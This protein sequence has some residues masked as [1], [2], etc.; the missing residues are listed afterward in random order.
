MVQEMCSAARTIG[1]F[2][3]KRP[4]GN[5]EH[6]PLALYQFHIVVHPLES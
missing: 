5:K 6:Q 2:L 1:S 4:G 3:K